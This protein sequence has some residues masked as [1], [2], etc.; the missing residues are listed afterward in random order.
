M[1]VI[2]K[3]FVF[4]I[5][6]WRH[7]SVVGG[8]SGA[9]PCAASSEEAWHGLDVSSDRTLHR[10]LQAAE[11]RGVPRCREGIRRVARVYRRPRGGT[12]G[13]RQ[14]GTPNG[15][16]SIPTRPRQASMCRFMRLHMIA[17]QKPG[18]AQRR[19]ARERKLGPG[20]LYYR[21]NNTGFKM[22]CFRLARKH[23]SVPKNI[24]VCTRK[25]W[26]KIL[27]NNLERFWAFETFQI[28]SRHFR[29]VLKH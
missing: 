9:V 1:Q 11:R 14:P 8:L 20:P 13:D 10:V 24:C 19:A 15:Q 6:G 4:C 29:F 25:V 7:A 16:A 2:Y 5:L 17:S 27:L 23:F 26:S 22:I 12:G 3:N 18:G 21:L 28:V